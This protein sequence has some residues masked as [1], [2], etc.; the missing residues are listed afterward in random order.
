MRNKGCYLKKSHASG[1]PTHPQGTF[2]DNT[3]ACHYT[4]EPHDL[5]TCHNP[6]LTWPHRPPH[7]IIQQM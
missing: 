7:P 1:D 3:W 5:I 6:L 4:Q 2:R